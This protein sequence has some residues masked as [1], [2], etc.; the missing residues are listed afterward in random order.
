MF[1]RNAEDCRIQCRKAKEWASEMDDLRAGWKVSSLVESL[2]DGKV[3]SWDDLEVVEMVA[4]KVVRKVV[5][6]DASLVARSVFLTSQWL[7]WLWDAF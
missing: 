4:S 1:R 7:G 6:K 5:R 2:V 3:V